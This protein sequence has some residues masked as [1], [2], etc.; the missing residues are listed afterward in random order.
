MKDP[1]LVATDGGS[2]AVHALQLAAAY[3]V[4]ENVP[5][6]VVSVV[7]P[8]SDLPMPLPHRDELEHA[9]ARGVADAVRRH[10]RDAVGDVDWPVHVCLGR[11]APAICTTARKR[12][13]RIVVLGMGSSKADG[14]ATAVELLHL[15]EKPLLV[16]RDGRL[17]TH[18]VVGIDFRPSSLRA[19]HQALR[20]L[21]PGGSAHLVHVK[22]SLDFPAASVW[23]WGPC[24]DCAVENGFAGLVDRLPAGDITVTT[25]IRGGAPPAVL[26]AVAEERG[27]DL[28][29]IGSDGY[30]CNDRVVVGR[31]AQAVLGRSA[32]SVLATPVTLPV[33]GSLTEVSRTEI[34]V[35]GT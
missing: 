32:V 21:Q 6:E 19:A 27:A 9:A 1:I 10:L 14:N 23:G 24:Y 34:M 35:Q 20:M 2:E 7:A 26:M 28:L 15:A 3:S 13:A 25:E 30:I 31:V 33:E 18:A 22:P 11:P 12:S 4:A 8:L 16:A 29:A 5:V 17:P